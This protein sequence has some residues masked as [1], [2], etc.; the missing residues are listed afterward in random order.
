MLVERH[1]TRGDQPCCATNQPS[2]ARR[3]FVAM[4]LV[5]LACVAQLF[6]LSFAASSAAALD[7]FELGRLHRTGKYVECADE[8]GKSIEQGT[9]NENIPALKLRCELELGR[10]PEALKTLDASLERFSSSI[11][12]RWIGR[13]VCRFAGQ[14]ERATKFE[15]EIAELVKQ[16]PWRYGDTVSQIVLGR[17]L[18][19]QATDPKRVL[20]G[21]YNELRKRQPN[22]LLPLLASG[23]LALDKQDFAL[24]AQHF[25]AALKLDDGDPD[26]LF[27]LAM[28]LAAGDERA[29]RETLAKLLM[30]NPNHVP[31]LLSLIDDMIDAERYTDAETLLQQVA[32]VNPRHP[33]AGAYRAVLAHLRNDL[34]KERQHRDAALRDWAKNP[35]VDHLIGKKLSQKYRFAEG[36][37]YQRQALEFDANYLPAQMQLAQDLLRLGEEEEGWKLATDVNSRDGYNVLAYNLVTLHDNL[38]KFRTIE[39]NGFVLRMDAKEAEIYG[40]ELLDLLRRA[41]TKLAAK[42]DVKVDKPVVVEIFPRQQDFAIR[43]FGL[44]GGAGF[45]GVCFGRVITANSPASQGTTPSCWQATL[46]HEFCHVITLHKTDNKL[47]RWLSEGISVYE[48]RLENPTWGQALN[49]KYREM[50]LGDDLTPV[51]Q[52]SSAFLA[53][54]SPLHL[55]F[56][57]FESALVIE[58]LVEKY[59]IDMLKRVLVDLGAGLSINDSLQ[60]YTGSLE[61]LDTE[62]AAYA[63]RRA[64]ALAPGVDWSPAEL[65][66]RANSTVISDWLK[67][68]P[69]NYIGLKRLAAQLISE[70]QFAAAKLPLRELIKLHPDD[71]SPDNAYVLLARLLREEKD[72]KRER[73]ALEKHA[74]LVDDDIDSFARLAELAA[75]AEDWEASMKYAR[76][77]LAVNP[78]NPTPHRRAAEAA[79]KLGDVTGSLTSYRALLQ[80]DPIDPA[81]AHFRYAVA[82]YRSGDK[83]A[84]KRHAL[85]ALEEAPRFLKAQRLLLKLVDGESS[86]GGSSR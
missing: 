26:A 52:L 56:A 16:S 49:P 6:T 50:L 33:R 23:D 84:A 83:A 24:A 10:Y 44:P 51:S 86:N 69:N 42:Y 61:A 32:T 78:L 1:W 18:L 14:P 36:Q 54:K 64:E 17:F 68:H 58:Y 3:R 12:L 82:L 15:Q 46:W 66:A 77:W 55:Q 63:R 4:V 80:L 76:R 81:D 85:L 2:P 8:C 59:G 25:T 27:G 62:F 73:L 29:S 30:Q 34:E 72:S 21:V 74:A 5:P 65:P 71:A 38:A 7:Y 67:E 19:S 45:L 20:D 28:A 35:E 37:K 41:R 40:A 9:F 13:D 79:E 53:P 31:S 11:Q 60:R 75:E 48:E 47:P 39:A 70:K 57:Y 22:S 43:T